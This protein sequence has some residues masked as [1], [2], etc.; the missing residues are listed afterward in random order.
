MIMR[1]LVLMLYLGNFSIGN[2]YLSMPNHIMVSVRIFM[3]LW[4]YISCAP[5]TD[6]CLAVPLFS[7]AGNDWRVSRGGQSM[8]WE[9]LKTLTNGLALVSSVRLPSWGL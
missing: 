4:W 6:D 3:R 9:N 5:P 7:E 2:S 1:P 8:A